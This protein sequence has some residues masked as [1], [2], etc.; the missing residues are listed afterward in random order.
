[1]LVVS[2]HIYVHACVCDAGEVGPEGRG[3]VGCKSGHGL[4]CVRG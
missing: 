1:M 3:H 4:P 2:L